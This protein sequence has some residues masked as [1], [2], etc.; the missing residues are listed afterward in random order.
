MDEYKIVIT[1]SHTHTPKH[2]QMV[3]RNKHTRK[4]ITIRAS[5]IHIVD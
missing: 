4:H 2:M 3:I 1:H 5:Q